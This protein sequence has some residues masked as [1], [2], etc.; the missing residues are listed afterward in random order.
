MTLRDLELVLEVPKGKGNDP[1]PQPWNIRY[2]TDFLTIPPDCSFEFGKHNGGTIRIMAR[3]VKAS[4]EDQ[5][6]CINFKI[7]GK[8]QLF[9]DMYIG[10]LS[11]SIKV[12][13][14][15]YPSASGTAGSPCGV[16]DLTLDPDLHG[17]L[18]RTITCTASGLEPEASSL[19]L[20]ETMFSNPQFRAW[21]RMEMRLCTLT[22]LTH[23]PE[24]ARSI[25]NF[26][27]HLIPDSFRWDPFDLW[28]DANIAQIELERPKKGG[29]IIEGRLDSE[30]RT[31]TLEQLFSD[32]NSDIDK[33][34][35][36]ELSLD[37]DVA[38]EAWQ[39][40]SYSDKMNQIIVS[41]KIY[42]QELKAAQRLRKDLLTRCDE[43]DSEITV[44]IF[45]VFND[46]V[47]DLLSIS[48]Q[49]LDSAG[50]SR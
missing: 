25:W 8:H 12:R 21:L 4:A 50:A 19:P 37:R 39:K 16:F 17:G 33:A 26:I 11:Q 18:Y 6:A 28:K 40:E 15:V 47:I 29:S 27:S 36:E 31:C 32:L 10:E 49:V 13:V 46:N 9:L 35:S 3:K 1:Q 24:T 2:Y 34:Q 44:C 41:L 42:E 38:S 43:A 48:G 45:F 14:E 5:S 22:Q 7:V 30:F 23:Y 20:T